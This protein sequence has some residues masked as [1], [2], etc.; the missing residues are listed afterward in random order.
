MSSSPLGKLWKR[1]SETWLRN[2][3]FSGYLLSLSQLVTQHLKHGIFSSAGFEITQIFLP[4]KVTGQA[5]IWPVI[6]KSWTVTSCMQLHHFLFTL[7]PIP[8]LSIPSPSSVPEM[9]SWGNVVTKRN[10]ASHKKG[11]KTMTI[12]NFGIWAKHS[13]G[14]VTIIGVLW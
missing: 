6:N 1:S 9:Y 14:E 4:A 7:A 8:S 11:T 13:I 3:Y 5:K 2:T 12:G 10:K